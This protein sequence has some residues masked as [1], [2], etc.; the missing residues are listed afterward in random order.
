MIIQDNVNTDW[1]IEEEDDVIQTERLTKLSN[2]QLTMIRHAMK[3]NSFRSQ[4][5]FPTLTCQTS[6]RSGQ[7]RIFNVLYSRN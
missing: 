5:G 7:N 3:C 1:F 4:S 6:S 2:F